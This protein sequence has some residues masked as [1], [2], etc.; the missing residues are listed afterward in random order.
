MCIFKGYRQSH[1][2]SDSKLLVIHKSWVMFVCDSQCIRDTSKFLPDRHSTQNMLFKIQLP[3]ITEWKCTGNLFIYFLLLCSISFDEEGAHLDLNHPHGN[4]RDAWIAMCINQICI[5][6]HHVH[7]HT[8]FTEFHSGSHLINVRF[9]RAPLWNRIG[10]IHPSLLY[11]ITFN[12]EYGIKYEQKCNRTGPRIG[13]ED[14]RQPWVNLRFV[15]EKI[16]KSEKKQE[17]TG[18][19]KSPNLKN[20]WECM[21]DGCQKLSCHLGVA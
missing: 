17:G 3:H 20:K 16:W 15:G 10:H 14:F 9:N 1:S 7:S 11:T 21:M 12:Y 2:P 5:K 8:K 18:T 6:V 13:K 19:Y 4:Y